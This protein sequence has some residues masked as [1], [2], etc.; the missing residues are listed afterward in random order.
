MRINV[1]EALELVESLQ[2]VDN[3][4]DAQVAVLEA[5]EIEV[6]FDIN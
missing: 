6:E 1:Q 3:D 5:E 4:S 2:V